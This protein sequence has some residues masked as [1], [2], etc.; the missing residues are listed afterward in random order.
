MLPLVCVCV[1]LCV[2]VCVCKCVCK[3]VC[4]NWGNASCLVWTKIAFKGCCVQQ[5]TYQNV[6]EAHLPNA[7]YY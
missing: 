5:T 7:S 1:C 2:C 3:C 4:V 6:A